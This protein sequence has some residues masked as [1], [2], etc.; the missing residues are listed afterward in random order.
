MDKSLS[1][2][3]WGSPLG[4]STCLLDFVRSSN[5]DL[6]RVILLDWRLNIFFANKLYIPWTKIYLILCWIPSY[7]FIYL[8]RL[9]F[10]AR[11]R[12]NQVTIPTWSQN[13][14]T[15]C[16][17]LLPQAHHL[18]GSSLFPWYNNTVQTISLETIH[19]N[20]SYNAYSFLHTTIPSPAI[21][22]HNAGSTKNRQGTQRWL[23]ISLFME[24]CRI[25]CTMYHDCNIQE[26]RWYWGDFH[27][28]WCFADI[29]QQE[30][31]LRGMYNFVFSFIEVS[32]I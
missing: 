18:F 14:K 13:K 27:F 6:R 22:L 19:F 9:L 32:F 26:S 8:A 23:P 12:F 16:G 11:F 25:W 24:L 15:P 17:P 3:V 4:N 29:S 5:M 21:E 1:Q 28:I 2:V 20:L 7:I 10:H 30:D 31:H